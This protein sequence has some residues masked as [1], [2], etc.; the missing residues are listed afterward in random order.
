MKLPETVYV[1]RS[2]ILKS[3]LGITSTDL[4]KAVDAGLLKKIAFPGRKYGKY[5]RDDVLQ[6][7][8]IKQEP[9]R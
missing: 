1:S 2:E 5:F 7:F 9:G 6:V 3:D 8:G 4:R